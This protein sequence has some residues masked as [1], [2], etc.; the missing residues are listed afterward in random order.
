MHYQKEQ[1][2]TMVQLCTNL[3]SKT[4]QPRVDGNLGMLLDLTATV[5]PE[6]GKETTYENEHTT[7]LDQSFSSRATHLR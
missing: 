3:D 2:K 5:K 4:A 7:S 6:S 1:A